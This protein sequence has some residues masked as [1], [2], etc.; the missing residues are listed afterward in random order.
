L[1]LLYPYLLISSQNYTMAP[2]QSSSKLSNTLTNSL[3]MQT[4]AAGLLS[5][6][7]DYEEGKQQ[8]NSISI[9]NNN[10]ESLMRSIA[11]AD[12]K[13]AVDDTHNDDKKNDEDTNGIISDSS[14]KNGDL[15]PA[16]SS[17]FDLQNLDEKT[18]K[19]IPKRASDSSNS[20]DDG[21]G[22][23]LDNMDDS[24]DKVTVT[25]TKQSGEW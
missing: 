4:T 22:I 16:S 6:L 17:G 1:L 19:L 21:E 2:L 10:N 5:T 7:I 15:P 3:K 13:T 18:K 25:A 20:E 9:N 23:S 11:S 24:V 14:S 8:Q 12:S